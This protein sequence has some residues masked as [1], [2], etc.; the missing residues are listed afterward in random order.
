[1]MTSKFLSEANRALNRV[2]KYQSQVN[3]TKRLSGIADDPQGTLMALRARNKLS[4]LELYR[5][6]I[7]T[8]S[9][10]LKEAESATSSLN[11]LLKSAYEDV[12]SAQSA[13]TPED[14]K[15]LAE[16]LKNLQDEVLSI[17][18]TTMGTS[19]L[20]GGFN[21]TGRISGDVKTPPF[22]VEENTG[23]LIYNGINLSRI[24]WKDDYVTA[25]DRMADF[26]GELYKITD[27]YPNS[28]IDGYA[29][30][31]AQKAADALNQ[32]VRNGKKA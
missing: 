28:V 8:A 31:Q 32:L 21:F 25:A 3:S 29:K 23:D 26:A 14:W 24:A 20:F 11:E 10:Y 17:S 16:N 19:Y 2:D 18:N 15:T 27:T 5:S 30:E 7:A 9:G 13:K 22:N 4:N 12:I 6:N 1:M